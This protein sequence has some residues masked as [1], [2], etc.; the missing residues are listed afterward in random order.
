MVIQEQTSEV[1]QFDKSGVVICHAEL[2]DGRVALGTLDGRVLIWRPCISRVP[3]VIAQRRRCPVESLLAL[4]SGAVVAGYD[5]GMMVVADPATGNVRAIRAHTSSVR[6]LLGFADGGFASGSWDGTVKTW[7]GECRFVQSMHEHTGSVRCLT[8]TIDGW[9][10]SGSD[11]WTLK[12]WHPKT[13]AIRTAFAEDACFS[14]LAALPDGG[15][16]AA[17]EFGIVH[18]WDRAGVR[19]GYKVLHEDEIRALV[20]LPDGGIATGS[21]DGYA[22]VWMPNSDDMVRS[23][24]W[25]AN[26]VTCVGALSD[27]RLVIGDGNGIVRM[28]SPSTGEVQLLGRHGHSVSYVTSISD[29]CV[30]S[31]GGYGDET[32]RLFSPVGH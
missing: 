30:L 16:V 2:L 31:A 29:G 22:K 13:G 6:C 24:S 10:V 15:Y 8:A 1:M 26:G 12:S 5:D 4:P 19:I 7:T 18:R 17:E 20:V 25:T 3:E 28:W 11:D 27:S 21:F 23:S 32:V 9:I 14:L